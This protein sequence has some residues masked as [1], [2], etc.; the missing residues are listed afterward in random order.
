M[1]KTGK[2]SLLGKLTG[3]VLLVIAAVI[4]TFIVYL[5]VVSVDHPPEDVDLSVLE[6]ERSQYGDHLYMAGNNW[7]RKSESGLW[8][9]YL[10]GEAFER[11]VAFGKLTRELLYYQESVFVDQIRELVPSDFYLKILKYFI[12][13]FNRNLEQHITDEYRHEIYGTSQSC[14]PAFDFIGSRYQRQLNYHS[15]HDIGHALADFNLIGCTSFSVWDDKSS[16]SSLIIG[17]N[18]DFYMGDRFS[19][20]KIVCFMNPASGYKFMMVTWADMIGVV[21]GMNEKGLTVTINAARSAVPIRSSTPVTLVTREIL[22]YA[23][24]ISEAFDIAKKREMFV[25]ESIM[26]GS[27]GDGLTAVIEKSPDTCVIVYPESH[28]IISTNH[29]QSAVFANDERNV[30]NIIG[31]DSY[32]RYQRVQELLGRT[33]ALDVQSAV[34]LLRDRQGPGDRNVGMGNQ[35]AINQLIAHHSVVFKP[36]S[37]LV[38]ISVPPYQLD[39]FVAYDLKKIFSADTGQ[40]NLDRELYLPERTI[41]ADTFLFTKD[42]HDYLV[43][44]NMTNELNRYRQE[45]DALPPSFQDVYIQLN[46]EYYRTYANLGD[47]YRKLGQHD[48]AGKFYS[49]ALTKVLPGLDE[50]QRIAELAA[51]MRK[52]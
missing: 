2:R 36:D 38:W 4:L 37:L 20:N 51:K 11:G 17:R 3:I 40:I 45:K 19:E 16:D 22:Q 8:E 33:G 10:E 47:Y 14:D 35:L 31:S 50:K 49:Q 43:F 7:L 18:F 52:K 28:Q 39:R 24:T 5:A 26:V 12:A 1:G 29:F 15:A 13:F 32:A 44:R 23:A 21:S 42:Y 34:H 27:S 41:P 46:P 9:C 48:P 30:T 6:M 25:S